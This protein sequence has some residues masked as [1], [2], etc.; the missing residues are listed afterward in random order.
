MASGC[1]EAAG[2]H[3]PLAE[4]SHLGQSEWIDT[5]RKVGR[6]FN[7]AYIS[8]PHEQ[9]SS[10]SLFRFRRLAV[11]PN[12]VEGFDPKP[13]GLASPA[14]SPWE[15]RPAMN[16]R[17]FRSDSCNGRKLE[18]ESSRFISNPN[19]AIRPD[20]R[21][22]PASGEMERHLPIASFG[23]TLVP[24]DTDREN[25]QT[26]LRRARS[27]LER[28][29]H[30]GEDCLAEEYFAADPELAANTDAA[31]DL[32]YA[33]YCARQEAGRPLPDENYYRRFP[34][35]HKELSVLF[36]IDL[37]PETAAV[38]VIG[39]GGVRQEYQVLQEIS[40]TANGNVVKARRAVGGGLV[41]IKTFTANHPAEKERFRTGA[42]EQKRL[43]HA[44]ILPVHD[45]GESEAGDPCFVMEFADAG[46]LEQ[47]I[48][49]KPQVPEYAARMVRTLAHA[50][51]YAHGEGVVHCDLK[52]ANVVLTSDNTPKITDFGLA[53]RV[54]APS[55]SHTT[56]DI[57]GTI[58][59]MAPE[60]AAGRTR[61]V[62]PL[63]DVY[64]LG[65]I[66]YEMLTGQPPFQGPIV[67]TLQQILHKPPTRPR[68]LQ[69]PIPRGL[70][71]IS[72]K[73]LEKKPRRR[74]ASAQALADDLGRWIEGKRPQADR[75]PARASRFARR[76]PALCLIA[77]L[78]LLTALLAPATAY[79]MDAERVR[80][81]IENELAAGR[82]VTLIGEE[83]YPPWSEW[84]S[85]EPSQKHS[86]A[87]DGAFRIECQKGLALKRLVRDPRCS[88][89]SFTAW[90]RHDTNW[91]V[92][93]E[94]GLFFAYS[95]FDTSRGTE[96]CYCSVAFNGVT[97]WRKE[98]PTYAGNPV[99]LNVRHDVESKSQGNAFLL[100]TLFVPIHWQGISD[101]FKI[102]IKVR[103]ENIACTITRK[104]GLDW[105]HE[106][107]G[108]MR[109]KILSARGPVG[110]L[111]AQD[112][113]GLQVF[114]GSASFKNVKVTPEPDW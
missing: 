114:H 50:M 26:R 44:N 80:E 7:L 63:S 19:P 2:S 11:F 99:Q 31:L 14:P 81:R 46:T 98:Y 104:E 86:L 29:I 94:I 109:E 32:I 41:A 91:E 102:T 84:V 82:E 110:E 54:D 27:E 21:G 34:Q 90:V 89:Y 6:I 71:S 59:Y 24:T 103:P 16:N 3:R 105:K 53:R 15:D 25:L 93:S 101:W 36:L 5:E 58:P 96:H 112:S 12:T 42:G 97:D 57:F 9:N 43:R 66:L 45:L 100:G 75:A 95:R 92:D 10:D 18:I 13:S 23:D 35:W 17:Y 67:E 39:P 20:H 69:R 48:A 1:C 33:E 87:S 47:Q 62:G 30:A 73:C 113:L 68:R 107:M 70:E 60:Q 40:E 61:D 37:G 74:Y 72:L 55:G 4:S 64:G 8:V 65:T 52:P 49:G 88:S 78:V 79:F 108:V 28:R 22:A 85:N 51:S 76:R 106:S 111:A 83:G 38:R 77:S 56:G